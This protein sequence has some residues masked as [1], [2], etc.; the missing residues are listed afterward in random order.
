LKGLRALNGRTCNIRY[1]LRRS[2]NRHSCHRRP[3][4]TA[5]TRT[6]DRED[7]EIASHR[8]PFDK[9]PGKLSCRTG[10]SPRR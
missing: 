7:A 10:K 8:L 4:D 6:S 3:Q 1:C 9:V 2:W 5:R